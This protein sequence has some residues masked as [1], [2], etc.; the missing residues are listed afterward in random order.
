MY[1]SPHRLTHAADEE[2]EGEE[3]EEGEEETASVKCRNMR[4][5]VFL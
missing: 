4:C 3:G 2:E 5:E 1:Q